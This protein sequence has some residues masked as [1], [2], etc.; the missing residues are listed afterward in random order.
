M[1]KSIQR[2]MIIIALPP[3]SSYSEV[4]YNSITLTFSRAV[5]GGGSSARDET[6]DGTWTRGEILISDRYTQQEN[7]LP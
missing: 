5:E 3:Q 2:I 7:S 6:A 4:I 1:Q